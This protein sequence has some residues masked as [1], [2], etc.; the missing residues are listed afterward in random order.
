[1]FLFIVEI[2][3]LRRKFLDVGQLFNVLEQN[4]VKVPFSYSSQ[5]RR[6]EQDE[7]SSSSQ[8]QSFYAPRMNLGFWSQGGNYW[9]PG[10][11]ST[12]S[13]TPRS[14][15]HRQQQFMRPMHSAFI[16]PQF[17]QI[18]RPMVRGNSSGSGGNGNGRGWSWNPIS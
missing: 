7:T 17:T 10:T 14:Y 4:D 8:T 5:R 6:L 12:Q 15:E 3:I 16:P 13:R 9:S 1:M 11:R 2:V 18:P